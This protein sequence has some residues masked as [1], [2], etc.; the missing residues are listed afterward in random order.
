L[1]RAHVFSGVEVAHLHRL[2]EAEVFEGHGDFS[3]G[4]LAVQDE[5]GAVAVGEF[6]LPDFDAVFRG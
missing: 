6:F 2:G 5:Q 4:V 1:R 3:G